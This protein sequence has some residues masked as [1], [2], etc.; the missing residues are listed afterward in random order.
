[1]TNMKSL[2]RAEMYVHMRLDFASGGRSSASD[3]D[4][5]IKIEED[6]AFHSSPSRQKGFLLIVHCSLTHLPAG[7]WSWDGSADNSDCGWILTSFHACD[8]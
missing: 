8:M 2:T 3:V 5:P 4:E 6:E 7:L 1:V